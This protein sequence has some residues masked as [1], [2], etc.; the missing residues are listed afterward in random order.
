MNLPE[1]CIRFGHNAKTISTFVQD[2]S[3]EQAR[4]RPNDESWSI[5][6]VINHFYDE[7]REDF[8][9]R[10]N[11]LLFSPEED[12]PP[13]DPSGWVTV[14]NYNE[15]DLQSSLA[16]FLHEREKSLEWLNDLHEP[17]W[18]S[19]REAPWGGIMRAGD[20][21]TS[22]LAHDYLH[23]RQLNEL[24]YTYWADKADPYS[25]LYAG[26]WE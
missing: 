17:N 6:E 8:R 19:G 15:R 3:A 2:I 18:E 25:G 11:L 22:W 13:I 9:V 26:E 20:M 4:W 16:N 1:I 7:E 24:H 14:R 23:I 10:L 5:L 21:M 12:W